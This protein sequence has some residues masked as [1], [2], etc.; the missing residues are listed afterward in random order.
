MSRGQTP[1]L[2]HHFWDILDSYR[3]RGTGTSPGT[4]K[5]LAQQSF[6]HRAY[7]CRAVAQPEPIV[8]LVMLLVGLFVYP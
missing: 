4:D 3:H 2:R 8:L 7:V 5:G 1:V 6:C